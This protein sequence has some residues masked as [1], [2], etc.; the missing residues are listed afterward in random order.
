MR[1]SSM[2]ANVE[3]LEDGETV[4]LSADWD[5]STISKGWV[6]RWRSDQGIRYGWK[7][8]DHVFIT[9]PAL[10]RSHALQTHP[11]TIASAAPASSAVDGPV[12]AWLSLLIRAHDGFTRSLLDLARTQSRLQVRLDG[13]YGS[14]ASLEQLRANDVN[15]LIAGGSGIAVVFPAIWALAHENRGQRLHAL[16]VVHSRS[17]H[18]WVPTERW[19]ELRALG[20]DV[21]MPEPTGESGMRPDLETY[22]AEMCGDKRGQRVGVLVSGPDGMNGGVRN[23]CAITVKHGA[24]VRLLVE[25]FGW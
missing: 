21:S 15:V 19:D 7:A 25:K 16:W 12:H 24:D 2:W 5:V 18:S 6:P 10:G 22:V 14:S 9:I 1:S 13:P 20:V 8:M 17:H 11:F 4:L 23:A 3:V